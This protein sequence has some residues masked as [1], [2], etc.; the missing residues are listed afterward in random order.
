MD[1]MDEL[2]DN[3]KEMFT[4]KKGKD[5]NTFEFYNS[6]DKTALFT[7]TIKA[8]SNEK[9]YKILPYKKDI[10]LSYRGFCQTLSARLKKTLTENTKENYK[11]RSCVWFLVGEK[12]GEKTGI[13]VGRN[14][15]LYRMFSGDIIPDT[16]AIL[17]IQ[18]KTYAKYN[19]LLNENKYDSLTFYFIDI[20]S[21]FENDENAILPDPDHQQKA[22]W[23]EGKTGAYFKNS[24]K[25]ACIYKTSFSRI[26]KYT[27]NHYI[28]KE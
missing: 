6:N 27:Y 5:E 7:V 19:G 20:D 11:D 8:N 17:G 28:I 13:Q 10:D 14:K 12:K 18:T 3:S 2:M 22:E 4:I 1:F 21:Y 16:K 15:N 9:K 25:D 23:T 26:E 24:Y